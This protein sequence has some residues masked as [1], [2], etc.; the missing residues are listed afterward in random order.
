MHML[1]TKDSC[2]SLKEKVLLFVSKKTGL[3]LVLLNNISYD[4]RQTL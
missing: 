1:G 2:Y 4:Y 3:Y